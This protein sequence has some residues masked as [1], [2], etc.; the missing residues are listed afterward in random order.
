[1]TVKQRS[2]RDFPA[3]ASNIKVVVNGKP[4]HLHVSVCSV[5]HKVQLVLHLPHTPQLIKSTVYTMMLCYR[6]HK[7][8]VL[9]GIATQSSELC[10]YKENKHGSLLHTKHSARLTVS[11]EYLRGGAFTNTVEYL[12]SG[13]LTKQ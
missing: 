6:P 8:S 4:P 11:V 1:M 9:A 7:I 2:S 12:C 3:Q 13:I 10:L 5:G